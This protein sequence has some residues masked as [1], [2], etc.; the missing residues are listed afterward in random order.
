M[1]SATIVCLSTS[2]RADGNDC[3]EEIDTRLSIAK[4]I[5]GLA[6]IV[7]ILTLLDCDHTQRGIG[8]LI[9]GGKVRDNIVLI[10][11]QLYVIL[12][13]DNCRRWVCLNVALQIH[14]IL[15]SLTEAGTWHCDNRCK[16]NLHI[17]ITTIA[18]ADTIIGHTVVGA[19]ILLLHRLDAQH[20]AHIGSAICRKEEKKKRK[21]VI[22]RCYDDEGCSSEAWSASLLCLPIR[23]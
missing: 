23:N 3:L 22:N 8:I 2:W 7:T 21:S 18:L 1:L 6:H 19:A 14:V 12:G 17:D 9:G 10:V 13:P 16:F 11:G 4:T 15:Q 20:V 5:C